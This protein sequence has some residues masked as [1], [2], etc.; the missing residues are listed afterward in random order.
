MN[1]DRYWRFLRKNTIVGKQ[2]WQSTCLFP[3]N[4]REN[5]YL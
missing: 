1:E 3:Y 4:V 5:S 2:A